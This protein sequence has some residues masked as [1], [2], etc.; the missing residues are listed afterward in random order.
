[1]VA[2]STASVL[3]T[4]ESGTGKELVARS[5]HTLSPR[6]SKP[7]V[8]INCS[9]I[10]ETLIESEIFGH[11]K[12]AFTGPLERRSGCFELA[13]EGTLLLDEIGEMPFATQAKLLRLLED[14][15]LRR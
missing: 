11:E 1:M 8:A 7:F 12:V 5:I 13:E 4:G 10:P 6:K 14:H 15:K 9:A 3:I 2:P